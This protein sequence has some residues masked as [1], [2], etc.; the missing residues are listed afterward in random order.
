MRCKVGDLAMVVK[1]IGG[2]NLG[3]IVRCVRWDGQKW[4]SNP[5]GSRVLDHSWFMGESLTA[6]DGTQVAVVADENL[7]PIRDEDGEDEMLRIAGKPKRDLLEECD[8][9]IKQ[10]N[11]L[12]EWG[13]EN[14][15]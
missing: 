7:K 1:S 6:W 14:S 9:L 11:S 8:R 15:K 2:R 5:D 13:K 12:P 10:F 4:F 3:K